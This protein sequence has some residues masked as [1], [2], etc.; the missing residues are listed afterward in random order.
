MN[1]VNPTPTRYPIHLLIFAVVFLVVMVGGRFALDQLTPPPPAAPPPAP[2]NTSDAEYI[3]RLRDYLAQDPT[4]ANA[5]ANL[6]L[7][8]LSQVRLTNDPSLYVQAEEAFTEALRHDPRQLNALIGQGQL[9][10]S[11]HEFAEA[12]AIADQVAEINPQQAELWAIRTDAYVELGQY[13]NAIEAADTLG[14]T[15]PGVAAYTRISYLRELQ[16]NIEGAMEMMSLAARSTVR[17]SEEMLWTQVQLGHL[18]FN[19]GR[20]DEAEIVYNVASELNPDYAYAQAATARL[21]MARGDLQGAI[22]IYE[23]L[24]QRLPLPEFVIALGELYEATGQPDKAEEQYGLVEVM[25]QLNAEAG[26]NVDLELALF[27]ANHGDKA[28]ALELARAAYETR[29]SIHAADALAWALH[30]TEQ[31]TE[32]QPYIEEAM[33][34]GTRDATLYYHAGMIAIANGDEIKGQEL[35]QEA[36]AINPQWNVLESENARQL[37]VDN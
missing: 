35:L 34:L 4:N 2:I 29:P 15:K 1:A 9:A 7:A 23:P 31:S 26:M 22:A 13:E 14:S 12:L 5:Y 20:Y 10:L 25:Q 37:V 33:R 27:Y 18:F 8:L 24:V 21:H 6:G 36:L 3:Q 11:R 19:A 30:Q 17:G 16:G 32:A 28:R